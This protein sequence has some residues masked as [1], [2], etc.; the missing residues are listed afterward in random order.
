M[1]YVALSQQITITDPHSSY[2]L[3]F[4]EGPT[5]DPGSANFETLNTIKTQIS[6]QEYTQKMRNF[7]CWKT[8]QWQT[9][10]IGM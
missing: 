6:M 8:V 5:V 9:N 2:E 4:L 3:D 1:A 7:I 10:C